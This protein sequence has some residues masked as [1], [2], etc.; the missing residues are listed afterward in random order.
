MDWY[1]VTQ[2]KRTGPVSEEQFRRLVAE[3]TIGSDTLVWRSGMPQWLPYA[4]VNAESASAGNSAPVGAAGDSATCSHCGLLFP[5]SEMLIYSDQWVCGACKPVFMQRL[6]EGVAPPTVMRF[7]GFWIR[8]VAR[9]LDAIILWMVSFMMAMPF[10]L[11]AMRAAAP[12]PEPA[13]TA[14]LVGLQ[15]ILFLLQIVVAVVYE[16]VFVGR[17][18][19]TPGKLALNLRIVMTGGRRVTY[20]RAC[21]RYF[22]TILSSMTLLIGYIIAAFDSEKR[23]L[24]DRI[25]DTRVIR[26]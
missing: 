20:G 10:G 7:G 1:Y 5:V 2:S 25:C 4:Q 23:A 3:G 12:D 17:F 18:G 26:A 19:A 15:A 16:T 11:S 8:F 13:A 24:H 6:V 22:A 9:C 14:G 21:G